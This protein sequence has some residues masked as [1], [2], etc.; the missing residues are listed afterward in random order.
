MLFVL[1][2][3]CST[4]AQPPDHVTFVDP[5]QNKGKPPLDKITFIHFK[6]GH[7]KP[8]WAGKDKEKETSCYEF[9]GKGLKLKSTAKY[10]IN[11]TNMDGLEKGFIEDAIYYSFE[12]WNG[13]INFE[14]FTEN[15]L[16]S[17][18]AVPGIKDGKN[19][20]GWGDYPKTGVIAVTTIWGYFTGPP[21]MREIIEFDIMFDTDFI[22]GDVE[23]DEEVMD[24][25]NIATHEIGHCAGMGDLYEINC[26]EETMYGYSDYGEIKK[27]DLNDGDIMGI[28]VL[29]GE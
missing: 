3:I 26:S 29:Y 9:I 18:E 16:I 13:Y 20:L 21:Q 12:E 5:P 2:W 8:P 17:D 11:P 6:K 19:T 22:W 7:A 1:L 14:L 28:Q 23:T 25:Q 10:T 24:L 15:Y 27:R 4:S